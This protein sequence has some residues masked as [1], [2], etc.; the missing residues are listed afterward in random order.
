MSDRDSIEHVVTVGPESVGLPTPLVL[1]CWQQRVYH[2]WCLFDYR[3]E[4]SYDKEGR[5]VVTMVLGYL[6]VS[7]AYPKASASDRLELIRQGMVPLEIL[8][9]PDSKE[10]P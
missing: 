1:R 2:D 9:G 3:W 8:R 6:R 7:D 4:A 10:Q 5:R